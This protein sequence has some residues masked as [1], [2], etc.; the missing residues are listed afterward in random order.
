MRTLAAYC[1]RNTR[2]RTH[3]ALHGIARPAIYLGRPWLW[4]RPLPWNWL[5]WKWLPTTLVYG[6]YVERILESA[7]SRLAGL[8]ETTTR[9][10]REAAACGF[11]MEASLLASMKRKRAP[12]WCSF[13]WCVEGD[14][15][16][17]SLAAT[18]P[19]TLRV[20]HVPPSTQRSNKVRAIYTPFLLLSREPWA[21]ISIE[22]RSVFLLMAASRSPPPGLPI[23]YLESSAVPFEKGVTSG[24]TTYRIG[25]GVGR[26]HELG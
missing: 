20:Y 6:I 16:P 15:N 13:K 24:Y 26:W 10:D 3:H 2:T 12:G 25:C 7:S 21:K 18:R 19:S 14:S 22:R 23:A 9:A 4:F 8:A 11:G 5:A 17:H 1:C